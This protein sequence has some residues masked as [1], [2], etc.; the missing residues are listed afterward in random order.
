MDKPKLIQ[1][2]DR[3]MVV[4]DIDVRLLAK[5]GN[6]QPNDSSGLISPLERFIKYFFDPKMTH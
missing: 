6:H 2:P 4:Q 5:E 3:A 1:G